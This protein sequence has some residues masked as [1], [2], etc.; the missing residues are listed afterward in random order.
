MKLSTNEFLS[1]YNSIPHGWVRNGFAW[2]F[3]DEGRLI[4]GFHRR[5]TL[6]DIMTAREYKRLTRL[7]P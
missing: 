3:W 2:D 4:V 6:D 5:V 1:K 7:S